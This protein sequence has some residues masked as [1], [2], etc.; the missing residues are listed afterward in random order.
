MHAMARHRADRR[1]DLVGFLVGEV[2]YAIDIHRVREI[3]RPL[4]FVTLPHAP[5]T[6]I[7]VADHRG[8]V[9]PVLDL[10]RR[11]GLTSLVT[12]RSKW[13]VI[14]LGTR[15]VAFAV[16]LVTA[17][18]G[19]DLSQRRVVPRI[20]ATAPVLGI[21]AVYA[22]EG[23]LVFVLDVEKVSEPATVI[24]V[25]AAKELMAVAEGVES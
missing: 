7:G 19:A 8:E 5:E 21:S 24:D 2:H 1:K 12:Q 14:R 16:D 11:F 20:G 18:F 9:V 17:V 10:R 13:I 15:S 23:S 4:S 6:V 25:Q 3:I 22:H